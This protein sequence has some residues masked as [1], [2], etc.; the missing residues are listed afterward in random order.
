MRKFKSRFIFTFVILMATLSLFTFPVG[1]TTTIPDPN[2]DGI[3]DISDIILVSRYLN[4]QFPTSSQISNYD[5]NQNGIISQF[6]VQLIMLYIAGV[7][8][9]GN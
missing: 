3:I 5:I 7:W 2:A 1:A 9:G 4:G 6:D 8:G